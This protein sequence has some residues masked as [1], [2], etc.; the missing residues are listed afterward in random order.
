MSKTTHLLGLTLVV[1]AC[2]QPLLGCGSGSGD[3]HALPPP[4]SK[5]EIQKGNVARAKPMIDALAQMSDDDRQQTA[6][7]PRMVDTL[8]SASADPTT[9]K[10]MD[11][12]GIKIK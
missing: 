2:T 11:D 4:V 9:K 3:E 1:F 10:R 5:A 12:L 7:S 6:N 8:R